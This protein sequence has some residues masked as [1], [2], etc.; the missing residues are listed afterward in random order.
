MNLSAT[1]GTSRALSGRPSAGPYSPKSATCYC[2]FSVKVATGCPSP[3]GPSA[4]TCTVPAVEGS[5]SVTLALRDETDPESGVKKIVA[6]EAEPPDD[7]AFSVRDSVSV[8]P[9][10]P[11]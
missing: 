10:A 9:G 4:V 11:D 8:L 1:I 2:A 6:P 7:P 5:V 3:K